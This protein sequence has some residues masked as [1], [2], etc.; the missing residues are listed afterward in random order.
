MV[1][2]VEGHALY[3]IVL[4]MPARLLESDVSRLRK[5]SHTGL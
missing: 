1:A 5:N 3:Q 4:A 2:K